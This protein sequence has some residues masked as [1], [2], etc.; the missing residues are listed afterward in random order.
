MQLGLILWLLV[1]LASSLQFIPASSPFIHYV[2]RWTSTPNQLRRD[3]TFP[4]VYLDLN[5]TNTTTLLLALSNLPASHLASS[6]TSA[7]PSHTATHRL[8]H[9]TFTKSSRLAIPAAPVSLLARVDDEEYVLLPNASGLVSVRADLEREAWHGVRVIAPM[10]GEMGVEG[11]MVG[12]E[13]VWVDEG[14]KLLRVAGVGGVGAGEG[15]GESAEVDE[16]DAGAGLDGQASSA[17]VTKPRKKLIEIITDF[18]GGESRTPGSAN[19]LLAGVMGWEYLL[20]EVFGV[21]HVSIAVDGMCL[22]QD[23]IGGVGSPAGI[24]DVVFRSGPV[25][26]RHFQHTWMFQEYVPDVILL[27]LGTTDNASFTTHVAAYNTTAWA[28]TTAFE[29]T[30]V[31]LIKALRALAYPVHPAALQPSSQAYLDNADA[32]PVIPIFVMRPFMGAMEHATVGVVRRVREDGDVGAFWLDT[33]GWLEAPSSVHAPL[34]EGTEGV[35]GARRAPDSNGN[36]NGDFWWDEGTAAATDTGADV[37]GKGRWRL[38]PRGNQ[39][40][41]MYLHGHLCGYLAEEG[42]R[43]PFLRR[44]VYGGKVFDPLETRLERAVQRG[45]EKWLRERVWG[46]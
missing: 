9:L 21:D 12:F 7:Q 32:P 28:L 19:G 4:G 3:G 43:C 18:P 6:S 35:V 36:G 13:G 8:A 44:E 27:N 38:T 42:S 2:G 15:G 30:Y 1:G 17:M 29:D 41:A 5:I 33:S 16:G 45:R 34:D 40:A 46:V 37:G 11:G 39:K 26:S 23:C 22:T 31:S 14:G 25:G 10:V 20:G 24:G